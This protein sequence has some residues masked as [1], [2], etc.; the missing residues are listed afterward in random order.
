[1]TTTAAP[2][3]GARGRRPKQRSR[4]NVELT[5]KKIKR[6]DLMNLSRQLSAFLR[7]G[8][9][10]LDAI[11][12][13]AEE[14]DRPAVRQT[15]TEIGT[16][17]RSGSSFSDAVDRFPRDF[18][19]FYRGIL[20][21]AELTGRL[22]A[23]LDQLYGYLERDLDARR[24]I[25]GAMIYPAVIAV[26]AVVA[27]AIL[28]IVVLPKFVDFFA[29]LDVELPLATRLLL[30]GSTFV[31]TWWWAL[32]GGL[33]AVVCGYLLGM[34]LRPV[35][36]LRDRLV[37]RIPA[38]GI[39]VRIA[40]VERFTRLLGSMVSAGCRCRRRWRSPPA[41]CATWSSRTAW[42]GPGGS[43]WTAPAWPARS[44]RPA[45]SPAWPTR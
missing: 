42:S 32:L 37:L 7:A 10:L 23:V 33:A 39:A 6:A 25:K 28:A 21:S 40:V 45:C 34:R 19:P 44:R 5:K 3:A 41:A 30:S 26:M 8:I 31:A 4:F 29:D 18:P 36:R 35:R 13:L 11:T 1:M 20:R 27:V 16:A 9:P 38:I 14:S 24:K 22:D 43:C 12:V 17:L 2:A 15:M